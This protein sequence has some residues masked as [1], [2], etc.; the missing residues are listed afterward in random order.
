MGGIQGSRVVI[1]FSGCKFLGSGA[2]GALF[3]LAQTLRLRD[4]DV[5]L[6]GLPPPLPGRI[7]P[8][9]RIFDQYETV[10]EAVAAF[11]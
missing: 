9:R 5:K 8:G 6:T 10:A 1:D 3:E 4:G 7:G 11:T 2:F